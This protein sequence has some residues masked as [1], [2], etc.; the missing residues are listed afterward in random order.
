MKPLRV[1]RIKQKLSGW[2][3]NVWSF[4]KPYKKQSKNK[5]TS[6]FVF[7]ID[8][9]C[10]SVEYLGKKYRKKR[11]IY[12]CYIGRNPNKIRVSRINPIHPRRL[13]SISVP[14]H[15]IVNLSL[16][17]ERLRQRRATSPSH[18]SKSFSSWWRSRR[19]LDV[20]GV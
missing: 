10:L 14:R 12:R 9:I 19:P 2:T 4:R 16:L 17:W 20:G 15:P 18:N 6:A 13:C 1:P 11:K 8:I 5:L 7:H 3:D